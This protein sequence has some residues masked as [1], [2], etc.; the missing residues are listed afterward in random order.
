[1]NDERQGFTKGLLMG[2]L[3]GGL[4]GAVL[5]VLYAPRRGEETREEIE[6]STRNIAD[7]FRSECVKALRKSRASYENRINQLR[8]Q[9]SGI[10]RK[11]ERL[12]KRAG[13]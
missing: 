9:E 6:A 1:M 5:G 11:I 8:E 7:Q 2:T 10:I 3:I 4:V 12:L 13:D